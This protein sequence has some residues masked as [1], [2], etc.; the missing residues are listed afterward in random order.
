MLVV[1]K[2]G[3]T[4]V[5]TIDRILNVARRVLR[6]GRAGHRV[7]AIVSAMSGETDRL[8][9]LAHQ[10]GERPNE[11]EVDVLV[12]TGEQVSVALL[13]LAIHELGGQALSL[14]GHQIHVHTDSAH[15]RARIHR[16]DAE[17]LSLALDR[18]E[19][20]VV[21]GFQGVDDEGN[22]TTLGRGGSDT[23]AVAVAAAL[24]ADVCEIYTDVDGVYTTDPG[25]CPD[26]RKIHRISYE[27]ML[28][29]ASLG[30]KVLQI[31]SVEVASKYQVPVHVRSS[32]NEE[33]GTMVVAE[34]AAMEKVLVTGVTLDRNDSKITIRGLPYRPGIQAEVFRPLGEA[35]VVLDI[36]VQNPPTLGRMDLSFTLPRLDLQRALEIVRAAA[37]RLDAHEVAAEERI[38]KV[39]IVGVG[40]RSHAGVAQRMFDLLASEGIEIMMITTSEI[41][42]SCVVDPKYGELAV[43]VLH[44][45][46][47]VGMDRVDAEPA[48]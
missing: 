30:A 18:G 7:V 32:F 44:E 25:I 33:E 14:L 6:T 13:A 45:G 28:E 11:R 31:R 16:I 27:E 37:G 2:Y 48:R 22:I 41:R 1:Q 39:S 24:R 26:A 29:L 23:S 3:G 42:V 9:K 15:S 12:S 35:G 5:G 20:P 21:A 17:R 46:F 8:L 38:A 19:I 10:I 40:M 4:S 47:A 34:E 43:R 36:I